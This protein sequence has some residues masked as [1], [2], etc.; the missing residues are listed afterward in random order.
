MQQLRKL[1]ITLSLNLQT[2]LDYF[3]SLSFFDLLDLCEDLREVS[4]EYERKQ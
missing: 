2:G 1:C 3:L 4:K